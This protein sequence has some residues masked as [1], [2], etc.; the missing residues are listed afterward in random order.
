[1]L[2]FSSIWLG[3]HR[4]ILSKPILFDTFFAGFSIL[5][6]KLIELEISRNISKIQNDIISTK[7]NKY[8]KINFSIST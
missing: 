3:R 8:F 1:V 5:I 2:I 6:R 7:Y 4:A